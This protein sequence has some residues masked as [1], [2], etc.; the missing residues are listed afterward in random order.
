MAI[1]MALANPPAGKER[2]YFRN[3]AWVDRMLRPS[4]SFRNK[5]KIFFSFSDTCTKSWLK[6]ITG[7]THQMAIGYEY[8]P[9]GNHSSFKKKILI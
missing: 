5:Q 6:A 8:Q 2:D 7:S 1:R 3:Q 4:R 9:S